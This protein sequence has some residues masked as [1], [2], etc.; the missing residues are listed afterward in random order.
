MFWKRTA[1][2][3]WCVYKTFQGVNITIS[4]QSFIFKYR[5]YN[6]AIA[7]INEL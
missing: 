4:R 7:L 5:H 2:F 6:Q 1:L 3:V